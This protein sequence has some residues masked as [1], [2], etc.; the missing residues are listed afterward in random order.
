M[1]LQFIKKYAIN[2]KEVESK[3]P[4]LVFRTLTLIHI[5][6]KLTNE[7]ANQEANRHE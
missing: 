5:S 6:T 1:G 3:T 7:S 2:I 4:R